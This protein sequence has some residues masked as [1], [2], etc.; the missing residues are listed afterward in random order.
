MTHGT[1]PN[2]APHRRALWLLPF[3]IALGAACTEGYPTQDVEPVDSLRLSN[4]QRLEIMNQLGH[5]AYLMQNWRYQL[6]V[7]CTL[8]I[9]V[10]EKNEPTHVLRYALPGAI[11]QLKSSPTDE[12]HDVQLSY[13]GRVNT[14]A[15]TL[16]KSDHWVEAVQMTALVKLLQRDCKAPRCDDKLS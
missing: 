12:A 8:T 4:P 1:S 13:P 11:V 16:L 2:V 6:D 9:R 5:E 14:E 3:I 7:S 15:M 10:E